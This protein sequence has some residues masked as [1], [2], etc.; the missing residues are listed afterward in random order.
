MQQDALLALDFVRS[1]GAERAII[2]SAT[3]T[4]KTI[5]SALDVRMPSTPSDCSS[6]SIA[7]RSSTGRFSEYRRVL[8]GTASD[9]GKLTGSHKQRDRRY[10]FATIQTLS[11]TER[12]RPFA[13]DAFDYVIIDEAHRAGAA[14]YQR[15]IEHFDP[16]FLLGMTATP[17]RTDGFNVFELFHYNV[18]Y[19]IRLNHALEAEML[20]PFHYYGVADITYDDGTTT[21]DETDLKLLI[22]PERVDHL[23]EAIELYGQ[24][25]VRPAD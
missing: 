16:K 11:K 4:G 21:T 9:Y 1:Q 8:G 19:E 2:I 12:S 24:A 20:C 25:G 10:V 17:E 13:P 23:L 18:P 22:T 14:T 15:V 6:S 5:L 7:S 3:G